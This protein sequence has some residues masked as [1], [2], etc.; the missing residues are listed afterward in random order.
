MDNKLQ[1]TAGLDIGNGYVKGKA[2]V[3]GNNPV[4]IDLPS[5]VSYTT[6]FGVPNIVTD[7]YVNNMDNEMDATITSRAIQGIDVGRVFF[8]TRAIRSGESLREFDINNATPKCRDALSTMLVL[9]SLASVALRSYYGET[10]TLPETLD[11]DATIGIA[12][13]IEDYLSQKDGYVNTLK[14][15]T[16]MVTIHNFDKNIVVSIRFRDVVPM[17]EGAAAQYAI[18]Q[19]GAPFL[20]AALV[21]AR[22]KGA[23]IDS[24]YTGDMLVAI[25]NT[26][27]IDVGEGT[28]N[29]PVFQNGNVNIEASRSINKG[30]GTVL[31]EVVTEV[32]NIAGLGFDSRKSLADF[33]L[34]DAITPDKKMKKERLQHYIDEQTS[35]FIR[36]LVKEFSSVY[37]KVGVNTDAIYIYGGGA[38][39][40][41]SQLYP[42]ILSEVSD[43][44]GNCL[45]V[46]YLDSSYSR[47]LNRTGLYQIAQLTASL[48][49][50][51]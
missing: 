1:I 25:T 31:S 11:V 29:F 35:I 44:E 22:N 27:G 32:R 51:E 9:G 18:T 19:L 48:H 50:D 28:V 42:A 23:N 7:E 43:S 45:P 30:Y 38:S 2:S 15:D 5:V 49:G 10:K 21:D 6:G 41:I 4:L 8:G 3:D 17:A 47:D 20:D 46:I 33:M 36:E 34:L 14:S 24:A 39:S 37:N 40:I 26:I 13:P 16:H 12:L